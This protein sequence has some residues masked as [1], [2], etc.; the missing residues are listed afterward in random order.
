VQK[1]LQIK[2]VKPRGKFFF[3]E[4][5]ESAKKFKSKIVKRKENF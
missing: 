1:N 3:D 5:L 2:F 4:I